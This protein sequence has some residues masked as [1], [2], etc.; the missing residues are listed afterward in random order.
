MEDFMV[1]YAK[2]IKTGCDIICDD[3]IFHGDLFYCNGTLV[4]SGVPKETWSNWN[5]NVHVLKS[6]NKKVYYHF[7]SKT[8]KE[9]PCGGEYAC[10]LV[11]DIYDVQNE[12]LQQIKNYE[13]VECISMFS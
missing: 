7:Q 9:I 1:G 3:M 6:E 11:Y 5:N 13:S 10:F 2:C 12:F 4:L 8:L